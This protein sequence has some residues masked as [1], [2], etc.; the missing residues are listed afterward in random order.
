MTFSFEIFQLWKCIFALCVL[1]C[2]IF[3][4]G[5]QGLVRTRRSTA[6]APK[7][8]PPPSRPAPLR[9]GWRGGLEGW[10]PSLCSGTHTIS[11]SIWDRRD[12]K[13][14]LTL[15]P[16][17]H[18]ISRPAS[19]PSKPSSSTQTWTT[20]L[21]LTLGPWPLTTTPSSVRSTSSP[22][23]STLSSTNIPW[24]RPL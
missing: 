15:N 13:G 3:E 22:Q 21:W 6:H 2:I 1:F 12:N 11:I 5:S 10:D 19:T 17:L 16:M 14:P 20:R 9:P 8:L 7:S 4:F 18:S 24:G 23:G